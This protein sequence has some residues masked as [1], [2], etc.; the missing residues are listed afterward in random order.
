MAKHTPLRKCIACS[1]MKDKNTLLRI[2]KQNGNVF[3]DFSG[4]ADGRGCYVCADSACIASAKKQRRIQRA[5]SMPVPDTLYDELEA[6]IN[7]E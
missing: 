6:F 4:K 2:V 7:H 5:F 1:K 3:F